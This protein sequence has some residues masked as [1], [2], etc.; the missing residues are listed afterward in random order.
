MTTDIFDF[1]A[2]I[3][4]DEHV[5]PADEEVFRRVPNHGF[6]LGALPGCFMGPLRT[7]PI[8]LLFLSP[9][10]ADSDNPTPSLIDWHARSRLGSE[11]LISKRNSP[12]RIRLVDPTNKVLRANSGGVS[13]E[14]RN[15]EYRRVPFE[16][17][18]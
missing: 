2:Q 8:V 3:G 13:L 6:E 1:W 7:A 4:A 12:I 10:L 14:S 9:G 17:I 16:D 11:P 5:H 15:T 18:Q